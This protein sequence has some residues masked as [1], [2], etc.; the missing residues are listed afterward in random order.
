[1]NT[2]DT[3][4]VAEDKCQELNL[5]LPTPKTVGEMQQLQDEVRTSSHEGK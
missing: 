2:E 3:Y 4:E 5:T 1:M